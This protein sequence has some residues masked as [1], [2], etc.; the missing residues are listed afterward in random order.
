MTRLKV[1]LKKKVKNCA[2]IEF[3]IEKVILLSTKVS[4]IKLFPG[5]YLVYMLPLFLLDFNLPFNFLG[6][7]M[8]FFVWLVFAL[9]SIFECIPLCFLDWV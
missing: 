3:Q 8:V 6:V 4:K 7:L 2:N 1:S 5:P 9:Q